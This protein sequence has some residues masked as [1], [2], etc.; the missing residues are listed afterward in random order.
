MI[1][2]PAL[3]ILVEAEVP[4]E[5][6]DQKLEEARS[7]I[8]EPLL[9]WRNDLER[10]LIT[11]LPKEHR[12]GG[13]TTSAKDN[14]A[15]TANPIPKYNIVVGTELDMPITSL[16]LDIQRLLRADSVFMRQNVIN[17]YPDDFHNQW[18]DSFTY[19]AQ[20]VT[21][22]QALLALLGL[23]DA[24]YLQMKAAG[25]KFVCGRCNIKRMTWKDIVCPLY[26]RYMYSS[27]LY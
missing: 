27:E 21:I 9:E 6:F 23:R 25:R 12:G 20:S 7:A 5:A 3:R 18:I 13:S 8:D 14:M 4:T 22:A 10:T 24:T 11:I 15:Q 17:F 2:W 26:V 19:G 16:P 1:Q